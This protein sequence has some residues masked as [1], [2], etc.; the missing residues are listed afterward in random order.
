MRSRATERRNLQPWHDNLPIEA[1][2]CASNAPVFFRI[3]EA[4]R[5][6]HGSA[7][8]RVGRHCLRSAEAKIGILT[9]SV[10]AAIWGSIVLSLS[11]R[12]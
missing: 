8:A 3:E 2:A 11:L 10:L 6:A 9:A 4:A 7:H 5:Q 12:R 1:A